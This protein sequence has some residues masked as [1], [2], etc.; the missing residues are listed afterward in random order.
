MDPAV[1]WRTLQAS[2]LKYSAVKHCSK[3]LNDKKGL[4]HA[5]LIS[6][7]Q[8]I[9]RFRRKTLHASKLFQS[10]QPLQQKGFKKPYKPLAKAQNGHGRDSGY[11]LHRHAQHCKTDGREPEIMLLWCILEELL[12]YKHPWTVSRTYSVAQYQIEKKTPLTKLLQGIETRASRS[13]RS[14]DSH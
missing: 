3:T 6:L 4:S 9:K 12:K 8:W 1:S 14:V 5:L 7:S 10:V 13:P 2:H 11:Q